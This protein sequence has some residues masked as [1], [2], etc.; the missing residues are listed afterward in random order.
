[1][2]RALV[3]NYPA[4]NDR[5]KILNKSKLL[6]NMKLTCQ[7][8][9]KE[10]ASS[11]SVWNCTCGGFLAVDFHARFPIKKIQRRPPTL[12]RYR[13]AIPIENDSHIVTFHEGFTP[14]VEE[15][16]G[17]RNVFLKLD[18]LFPSGSFKDR[19]ASVLVSKIC[20]LGIKKVIED[21]S[22]NAGAAIAA[23]CAKAN[24]ACE[25]YVPEKT[26]S[27][28][29]IQI[30]K[31]GAKLYKIHGTRQN[32][33]QAALTASRTTYFASHY[34]NPF[35]FQ[36]TKTFI[37]EVVEQLGWKSPDILF[38]PVGN[39]T[40]LYGTYL[41][42]K[43]LQREKIIDIPPRIIGIQAANC[44]PLVFAWKHDHEDTNMV[45]SIRTIADGLAIRNPVR[46]QEILQAIK[47]TDGDMIAVTEREIRK[48]L[49]DSFRKGYFI[50][51]TAAV[52]IAGFKKYSIKKDEVAVVTLTGH[53]LKASEMLR[54]IK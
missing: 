19:G 42:L 32:A 5:N 26:S 17:E 6:S 38:L 34:R 15:Q 29:L 14:L 8:C 22:G 46:G 39:G 48:A 44:A 52:A 40:L 24:I 9:H 35:F 53:G 2:L 23:Y 54:K 31:Y 51:P 49:R 12:W 45:R 20:E 10:Y 7:S 4:E 11:E 25:I 43:D 28:K 33:A 30:E 41:G 21:S 1:M 37:F 16:Y 18:Y 3:T 47:E 27:S 13:E 50:E 36:G